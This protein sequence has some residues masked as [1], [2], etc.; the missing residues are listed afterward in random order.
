MTLVRLLT[1][2]APE[3]KVTRN[4]NTSRTHFNSTLFTHMCTFSLIPFFLNTL[5][6]T[7]YN[8]LFLSLIY[9]YIHTHSLSIHIQNIFHSF[10]ISLSLSLSLSL[11][12]YTHTHTLTHTH[13]HTFFLSHPRTRTLIHFSYTISVSLHLN[14]L[15]QQYCLPPSTRCRVVI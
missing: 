12:L 15:L 6:L 8:S 14:Q 1:S 10:S 2:S 5:S 7:F 9:L 3:W 4:L 11:C 13:K